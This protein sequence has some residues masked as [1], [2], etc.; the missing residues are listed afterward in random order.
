MET[1]NK[2]RTID[3][4]IAIEGWIVEIK[5]SQSFSLHLDVIFDEARLGGD[6]ELDVRFRVKVKSCEV[7]VK[8]PEKLSVDKSTV[9]RRHPLQAEVTRMIEQVEESGFDGSVGASEKGIGFLVNLFRKNKVNSTESTSERNIIPVISAAHSKSEA[10]DYSW[11]L[12]PEIGSFLEGPA[13]NA[14]EE[15][16]M[17]LIDERTA[18]EI[19]SDVSNGFSPNVTVEI[20]CKREDIEISGIE[21]KD[22]KDQN[23]FLSK[24]NKDIRLAAAE[25][26]IKHA[27]FTEGLSAG[28]M[29]DIFSSLILAD[30]IIPIEV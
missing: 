25:G 19:F 13:W 28:D 30:Y 4:L 20:H 23:I 9:D 21:M 3:K 29:S 27:L 14:N 10:G 1:N 12:R 16:R 18:D 26:Y 6:S 5:K 22:D 17:T 2:L 8:I 7:I 15:P 24:K 11:K